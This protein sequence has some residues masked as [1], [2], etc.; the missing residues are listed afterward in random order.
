MHTL[1]EIY[2]I[3]YL[4][5]PITGLYSFLLYFTQHQ[6]SV[7]REHFYFCLC[8]FFFLSIFDAVSLPRLLY[9]DYM[10]ISWINDF[11]LFSYILLGVCRQVHYLFRWQILQID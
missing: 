2:Q 3:Q 10:L 11:C 8:L 5:L 4:R 1:F 9:S 7:G 6:R